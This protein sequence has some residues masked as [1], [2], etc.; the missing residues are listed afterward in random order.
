MASRL[1]PPG[2]IRRF[3]AKGVGRRE[4]L[5]DWAGGNLGNRI[6]KRSWSGLRREHRVY[7]WYRDLDTETPQLVL[8]VDDVA[9]C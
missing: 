7:G 5:P 6:R 4:R 2:W 3:S 8:V 9:M 1:L